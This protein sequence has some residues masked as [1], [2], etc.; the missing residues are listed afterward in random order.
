MTSAD[1]YAICSQRMLDPL[2]LNISSG[3]NNAIN[4]TSWFYFGSAEGV[5]RSFPGRVSSQLVPEFRGSF[6]TRSLPMNPLKIDLKQLQCVLRCRTCRKRNVRLSQG[7][8]PGESLLNS[9]C[10]GNKTINEHVFEGQN[11][12]RVLLVNTSSRVLWNVDPGT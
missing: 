8:V 3:H 1:D 10:S 5:Q 4:L 7:S 2:F 9:S 6:N 11:P 12:G